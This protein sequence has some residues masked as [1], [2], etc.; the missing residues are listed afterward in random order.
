MQY[1]LRTLLIVLALGP[2]VLAACCGTWNYSPLFWLAIIA[3]VYVLLFSAAVYVSVLC[4]LL[5][6]ARH[7]D[8]SVE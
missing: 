1:R 8:S 4:T 2:P 6:L 3:A 7:D 5:F